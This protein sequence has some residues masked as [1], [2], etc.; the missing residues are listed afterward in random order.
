[1]FKSW[2]PDGKGAAVLSFDWGSGVLIFDFDE[3]FPDAY[4]PH[5]D[6][7][8]ERRRVGGKLRHYTAGGGS[9]GIAHLRLPCAEHVLRHVVL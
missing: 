5:P 6:D 3:P 8:P 2:K 9:K 7:T 1:V 4:N